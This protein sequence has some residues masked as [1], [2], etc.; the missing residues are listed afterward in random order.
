M[1][2]RR[3][4]NST[5]R[6][7]RAAARGSVGVRVRVATRV[8][9]GSNTGAFRAW[10]VT[11][12]RRRCPTDH[13][14]GPSADVDRA[15]RRR[16][17]AAAAARAA[18][19]A[20]G[21]PARRRRCRSS[22][23]GPR[24][25]NGRGRASAARGDATPRRRSRSR[26]RATRLRLFERRPISAVVPRSG[27][28]V[29]APLGR[30]AARTV[31]ECEP[32]GVDPDLGDPVGAGVGRRPARPAGQLAGGEVVAALLAEQRVGGVLAA[33]VRTR[34]RS[35]PAPGGSRVSDDAA[36]G[37]TSAGPAGAAAGAIGLAADVAEVGRS[38]LRDPAG[39]CR[40]SAHPGRLGRAGV[41]G[42]LVELR[43][44]ALELDRAGVGVLDLDHPLAA[45][46]SP[47]RCRSRPRAARPARA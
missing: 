43:D 6:S 21:R 4:S 36:R 20:A 37:A 34:L 41:E 12:S 13:D 27:T 15:R 8:A 39:R 29:G 46:S 24:R 11:S 7:R 30:A 9:G 14:P 18:R 16:A 5:L 3:A 2:D 33:A 45:C 10:G 31:L 32:V 19:R 23:R 38:R 25:T 40:S 47:R 42:H 44:V 22:S 26:S 17:R 1:S 35:R 28:T